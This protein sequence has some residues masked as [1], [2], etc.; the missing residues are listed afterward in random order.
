MVEPAAAPPSLGGLVRFVVESMVDEPG[1]VH[2]DESD[3]GDTTA[4]RVQVAP[5]D[6]GKVIGRQGRTARALRTVLAAAGAKQRRRTLLE[7]LE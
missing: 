4:F 6:L 3:E 7:I 5:A 1:A 2:I